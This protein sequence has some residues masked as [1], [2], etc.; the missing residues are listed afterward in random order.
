MTVEDMVLIESV[1][2]RVVQEEITRV[3]RAQGQHILANDI[4]PRESRDRY[5]EAQ[6]STG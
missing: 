5:Q 3:L 1:V 2:R 6:V 4:Y